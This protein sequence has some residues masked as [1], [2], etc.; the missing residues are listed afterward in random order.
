MKVDK[1]LFAG[2]SHQIRVG[3][4]FGKV[5]LVIDGKGDELKV[6][7]AFKL[8]WDIVIKAGELL[9]KEAVTIK[10]NGRVIELNK[11]Q[12]LKVGGAL[13]RKCDAADDF[14]LKV[15]A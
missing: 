13:L 6:P 4:R 1:S 15:S 8:G 7:V 10:I 9:P 12:G 3:H 11:E 14:Q 5:L 2:E